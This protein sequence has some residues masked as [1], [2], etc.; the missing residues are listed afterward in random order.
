MLSAHPHSLTSNPPTCLPR[1]PRPPACLCAHYLQD[2]H[3]HNYCIRRH[4]SARHPAG[5][6]AEAAHAGPTVSWP[7]QHAA[8]QLGQQPETLPTLRTLTLHFKI[9]GSLPPEWAR[10]FRRLESLILE[11]PEEPAPAVQTVH[12]IPAGALH[13]DNASQQAAGPSW[14]LPREWAQ[15]FPRLLMLKCRQLGLEGRLADSW[16]A[17]GGFP[18]LETL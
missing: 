15:G 17:S 4:S 9:E 2:G 5:G 10:G 1:P 18:L 8:G 6:A 12:A 13:A 14:Q 3:C 16:L 11:S 7:A